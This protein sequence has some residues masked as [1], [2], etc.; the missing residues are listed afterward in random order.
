LQRAQLVAWLR[1]DHE[2]RQ[3]AIGFDFLQPFHHLE[4][5]QA[6]HLQIEQDQVVAVLA[7]K[8]A[9]LMRVHRGRDGRIASAAQHPLEQKDIGFLIVNDQDAGVKNIGGTDHRIRPGLFVLGHLLV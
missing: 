5:V 2:D 1:G 7:V 9:D 3:V 8:F 4:S 6:G